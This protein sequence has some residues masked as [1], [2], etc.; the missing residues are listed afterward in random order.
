MELRRDHRFDPFGPDAAAYDDDDLDL[1]GVDFN[2]PAAFAKLLGRGS[3]LPIPVYKA[4][5]DVRRE[6]K[7]MSSKIFTN[8]H[9]LREILMRHEAAIQKRWAKKTRQQRLKILVDAWPG[10]ARMHRPDFVAFRAQSEQQRGVDARHRD[11]YMWPYINQ[12]DL[13]RPKTLPL[14]LNA[15]GRHYPSDFAAADF[16]AMHLGTVTGRLVPIFLNEHTMVLHGATNA[17]DYGKLLSWDDHPDAFEWMHTRKQFLPGEGLVVLEA[18]ERVLD[19]LVICCQEILRDIPMATLTT[20]T[21][22]IQPEPHL[23]TESES[24]G[25]Q[26]LALMAAEAPYRLP[27]QLDLGRIESLLGA[28]ASAAEDHLWA[29]REDPG[30]FAEQLFEV[31]ENRQ[32]MLKDVNGD[33]HPALRLGREATFWT[34]VIGNVVGE[35]YVDLEVY[36]ELRQQAQDLRTL[37]TKYDAVIS[38]TEDLPEEY[39]AALLK[40][41]HYLNQAA[42]GPLN[43]LRDGVVASPAMRKFFVREPAMDTKSTRIAV[44]SKSG[45][46]MNNIELQLI[47]LLRTLWEDEIA[48]FFARLPLV[49]DELERLLEAEP[50]AQA[51]LSVR[52]AGVIGN[53]SILSQC[54]SQL[55]L[56]LPWARSFE[57]ALASRED[58][59]KKEF[60]DRS[61]PWAKMIAALEEKNLAPVAKLGNPSDKKFA[62]P[63]EKRRTKENVEALR[64]AER[65]LDDFWATVDQVVHSKC[66]NLDGTAMR[67][68]LSQPRILQRTPEWVDEPTITANNHE[69]EKVSNIQADAIYKPF[70]AL[71]SDLASDTSERPGDS[72]SSRQTLVP[73]RIKTKTRGTPQKAP[74][75]ITVDGSINPDPPSIYIPVDARALKTFRTIFF[76]PTVTSTPGEVSWNDFLH[77]MTS[78]G[79]FAAE[80]LYGSVWQFW[81]LDENCRIQFHEPHPRGK[82]PFTTARRHG[83]RLNRAFGWIGEMF[84]LKEK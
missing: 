41:R 9:I 60:A 57:N 34:R 17:Q 64:H 44:R 47:W 1:A 75:P 10:M 37:Q 18:Q 14:L 36:S 5:A 11:Y 3:K 2:D 78:T 71:Y 73:S 25:F 35:A 33:V 40:F 51:L 15:R 7:E 58:G 49:L 16:E 12:E 68:V 70:S 55:D 65:N 82:I 50:Q 42:K 39:L 46:N 31:K 76:N 19:F 62:Y 69:G 83:R 32:E 24:C 74:S 56:Y 28:R 20:G 59:I 26:S 27:A 79:L 52:I 48:L 22:P 21:F 53:L 4:P 8:F 6:A 84:V 72:S 61:K 45:V 77:A 80:K 66:G 23:K 81:K 67:R 29:L 30:Y 38:P 54:L 13:L 63:T 43:Q